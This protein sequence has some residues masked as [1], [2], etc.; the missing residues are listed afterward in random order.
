MTVSA[1]QHQVPGSRTPGPGVFRSCLDR[2][3]FLL[4]RLHSLSGV[5]PIGVFLFPHLTTNASIVWGRM[6]TRPRIDPDA[7]G[8]LPH[9]GVETFQ[10]EVEFIH[11]LPALPLIEW[12]ILFLPI[13]FHAILGVWFAMSGRI[14]VDRYHYQGNWRYTLQRATGYLG[15]LFIFLHITS[16]R[17]GW[18][19]GGLMPAFD[20]KAASSSVA[21]HFQQSPLGLFVPLFYL[22]SSLS[23]IFHFANGL[24][25][26]AITWGMTVSV[27]AQR[28]W[29]V[30][31][32]AVGILLAG[33]AI[34]AIGGFLF[35]DIDQARA[36]EHL[37][38]HGPAP[39]TVT[40]PGGS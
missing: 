14:N 32:A 5:F 15:I 25:T 18:E 8:A 12:G 9:A 30:V 1:D 31:C 26:A 22:V 37:L 3:Y 19:Y 23:L 21:V 4:R 36:I 40:T 16:L 29:G 17:F 24:W 35:L 11:N 10:H 27:A 39:A 2:H 20:G 6:L 28:R 13:L 33:L 34:A 38:H 7:L